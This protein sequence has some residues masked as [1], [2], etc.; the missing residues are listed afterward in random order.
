[1]RTLGTV[2]LFWMF[3]TGCSATGSWLDAQ[4]KCASDPTCMEQ[5]KSYAKIGEA[6][7]SPFGPIASAGAGAVIT[8]L[9]L[10]FLG[11]RKKKELPELTGSITKA[12][13]S[14]G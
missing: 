12:G 10:G 8:F 9:A 5:T 6:V 14:N 11:F 4:A 3:L 13:D 7:V 1:M 2:I